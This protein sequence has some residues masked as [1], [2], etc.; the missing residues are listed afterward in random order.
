[1]TGTRAP[2]STRGY[3]DLG[4]V[5]VLAGGL[6]HERDVSLRSGR[7]VA[8][9][10]R[11]VGVDVAV[12]DVDATLLAQ[13]R[14]EPPDVVFPLLHGAAGEDGAMSG[15]LEML[16]LPYVGSGPAACRT[17]FDK[18]VAKAVVAASGLRTPRPCAL[19]HA[20]FRELGGAAVLDAI[21]A[22][23]GLPLVVKPARGGSALGVTIVQD[24]G[25]LP[26]AMVQ[27]F[28][29]GD[30]ALVERH[31]AGTE[32]AVAVVDTGTGPQALSPV[33]IVPQ[34][35]VYDYAARYSAGTTEFFAP[36]RL[37]D[38]VATEVAEVALTAHRA[39]GS[40]D[41]SAPTSSSTV[42]GTAWFLEV[43]WPPA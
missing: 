11:S 17:A 23:L 40:R 6:S 33:E 9:A 22:E 14:A 13:V 32:V 15:V 5:L 1:M 35:A 2:A 41:L 43:T 38:E 3:R 31:V 21:V 34:G 39:L 37:A 27:A 36:A 28:A 30:T 8:D 16:G 7:R 26:V 20:M 4:T 29:Y 25:A 12:S 18:P 10:L 42:R 24:I 19:P